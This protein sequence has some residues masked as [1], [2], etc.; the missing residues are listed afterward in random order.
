MFYRLPME[1]FELMAP[2]SNS[3]HRL[4]A[5]TDRILYASA[6]DLSTT[7]S[8]IE[9][10]LYTS[11]P[12]YTISDHKPVMALL[13]LPSSP[14]DQLPPSE[15]GPAD[16]TTSLLPPASTR[17]I[18]HPGTRYA[19][20]PRWQLKRWT[21][22]TLGWLIGWPWCLTTLLGAGNAVAGVFNIVLGCALIFWLTGA[23]P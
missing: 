8:S 20:D 14:S 23:R 16:S 12:S 21:G 10:L 7:Q 9:A 3:E 15:A 5:W 19:P 6:S 2:G 17:T 18:P 22:K 4:P 1:V 13:L 11:I